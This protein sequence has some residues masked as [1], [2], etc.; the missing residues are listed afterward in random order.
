MAATEASFERAL[1]S[2]A[3]C[4]EPEEG[5]QGLKGR[6]APSGWSDCGFPGSHSHWREAVRR[7]RAGRCHAQGHGRRAR[8]V[9]RENEQR[10]EEPEHV[11]RQGLSLIRWARALTYRAR[12]VFKPAGPGALVVMTHEVFELA[13]VLWA[14]TLAVLGRMSRKMRLRV[15]TLAQA[16]YRAECTEARQWCSR[17]TWHD[18]QSNPH[19][20]LAVLLVF[21]LLA[22]FFQLLPPQ[23]EAPLVEP[24]AAPRAETHAAPC[25]AQC[26]RDAMLERLQAAVERAH[27]ALD[28]A[29][30]ALHA[31]RNRMAVDCDEC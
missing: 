27:G 30:D 18:M 22:G 24:V 19:S 11:P 20:V 13:L 14:E 25:L 12:A 10:G 28:T 2:H 6:P 3:T 5:R 4:E 15:R 31:A 21:V 26:R 7:C 16:W 17:S 1:G 9:R 23:S 29:H 8:K